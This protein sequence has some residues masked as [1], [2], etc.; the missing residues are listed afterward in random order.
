MKKNIKTTVS[1][2]SVA[3]ASTEVSAP[4]VEVKTEVIPLTKQ[5]QEAKQLLADGNI[6]PDSAFQ[7]LW[8]ELGEMAK[9]V[10]NKYADVIDF[11]RD[12]YAPDA[13]PKDEEWSKR[14]LGYKQV[15]KTLLLSGMTVSA[16]YSTT[17][18]LFGYALAKNAEL[19]LSFREGKIGMAELR[20]KATRKAQLPEGENGNGNGGSR[21]TKSPEERIADAIREAVKIALKLETPWTVESFLE[22]AKAVFD[23]Q[24]AIVETDKLVAEKQAAEKQAAEK[25]S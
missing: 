7:T 9:T 15:L 14:K 16:S 6:K 13:T 2:K 1:E 17:S 5:E 3:S 12:H 24:K 19:V 4:I 21:S 20:D 10:G 23:A 25:A 18:R 22:K 11:I 8:A